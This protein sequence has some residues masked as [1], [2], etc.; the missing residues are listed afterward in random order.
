M[1]KERY[2]VSVINILTFMPNISFRNANPTDLS[3]IKYI[4][5]LAYKIPYKENGLITKSPEPENLKDLFVNKQFFV[6]VAIVDDKIVGAVR[7]K[8]LEKNSLYL[9]KLAVL[10]SYRKL[11]IG[12]SLIK[13]VGAVAKK[14][15]LTKILLDCAQE[16]KLPDY[17]KKFGFKIDKIKKHQDHHDVYMSKK[18]N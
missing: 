1:R 10:K 16:K 12:E 2:N 3:R 8:L 13:R 14:K 15:G 7:Y 11:G 5:K 17:Y 4:T 6:I 9:Y 18:I